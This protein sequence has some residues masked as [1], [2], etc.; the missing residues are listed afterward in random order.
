MKNYWP[1]IIAG[2]ILI[3]DRV[4]KLIMLAG[5]YYAIGP[6]E[7]TLFKNTGLV[8]SLPAP[9][10][11]SLV[12]MIAAF[13]LVVLILWRG[14]RQHRL[15]WPLA[16][17]VAGAAS[18]LYDRVVHGFIID[19]VYI[20]DW[21]PIFNLADAMLTAAVVIVIWRTKKIDKIP[22]V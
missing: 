6:F 18:N 11:V 9:Y 14:R 3:V 4:L 12:L 20:A 5:G 22:D 19:Y 10:Y 8:F 7:F 15:E 2:I 1:V 16:L 21:W 17:L 13:L